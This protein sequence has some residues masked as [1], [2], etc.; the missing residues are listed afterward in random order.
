ME[1]EGEGLGLES[2]LSWVDNRNAATGEAVRIA[3]DHV[4]ADDPGDSRNHPMPPLPLSRVSQSYPVRSAG[5]P[6]FNR[7]CSRRE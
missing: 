2:L 1:G 7:P 4:G 6:P 5:C 3:G